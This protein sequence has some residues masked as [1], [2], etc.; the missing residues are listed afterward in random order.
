MLVGKSSALVETYFVMSRPV[1]KFAISCS[2]A[3]HGKPR[4]L[5]TVESPMFVSEVLEED[6]RLLVVGCKLEVE[7]TRGYENTRQLC[8]RN[9]Y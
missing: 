5:T 6:S 2:V 3:C 7:L 1:K 8:P 9:R 4:A